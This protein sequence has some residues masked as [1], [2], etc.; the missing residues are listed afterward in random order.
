[1]IFMANLLTDEIRQKQQKN[2]LLR[3]LTIASL[4]VS[5]LLVVIL[6]VEVSFW[7]NLFIRQ[8][9]LA[10]FSSAISKDLKK[11]RETKTE[12]SLLKKIGDEAEI[13]KNYSAETP[14]SVMVKEAVGSKPSGLK[15][16]GFVV[17]RGEMGKAVKMS[18]VGLV[19]S[20]GELVNYVNLLRQT[21]FF[22]RVDLPVESLIS[23]R[24]GQFVISLEK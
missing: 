11:S 16:L 19:S 3:K 17:E 1:M 5:L 9:G 24:G 14:I 6:V 23:D 7:A 2:L 10:D 20:R 8:N 22:S 13:I 21:K 12:T 4:A 15:I 18:L